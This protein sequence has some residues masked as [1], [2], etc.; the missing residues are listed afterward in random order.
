MKTCPFCA[1]EIQDAAIKCRHC[2]EMLSG[3]SHQQ[4]EVKNPQIGK[5][6]MVIGAVIILIGFFALASGAGTPA[7]L[8]LILGIITAIAGKVAHWWAWE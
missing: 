4:M 7:Y 3:Q 6:A 8:L 1:E 2:G 5:P